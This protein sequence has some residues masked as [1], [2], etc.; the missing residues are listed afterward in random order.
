MTHRVPAV[1]IVIVNWNTRDLLVDCVRSVHTLAK[2]ECRVE[3]VIV[4][5]NASS[6]D[7]LAR[8]KSDP[9]VAG[10]PVRIVENTRNLGFAA[11]C[12]RG[13]RLGTTPYLLFLN[14]DTRLSPRS[15][16]VPVAFLEQP[17]NAKV[18][19]CGIEIVD[20][21][22]EAVSGC[23][24]FPTLR[25]FVGQTTQL[26]TV[27]PALFP[28]HQ[29]SLAELDGARPVDQIIG[30]FF[31]VRR[32]VFDLLGGFDERFFVY[33][34]E[35]DFAYRAKQ[36]GI[37]SYFVP[38][39]RVFHHGGGSTNAVKARRLFLHLRSRIQYTAKHFGPLQA[40]A[41]ALLTVGVELPARLAQAVV[42]RSPRSFAETLSGYAQLLGAGLEAAG[43]RMRSA[44][45]K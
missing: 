15:L 1:D 38:G 18:G 22:G 23:Y 5:D 17:G 45:G 6:D 28:P 41:A 7:S 11:S 16:D 34:E 39:A 33:F 43:R 35:V 37:L 4:V 20:G 44:P 24:R 19:I 8:L 27:A 29:I 42:R 40:T 9:A 10:L 14:P 26:S 31:L 30:A 13:A 2:E 21:T 3:Q 25:T 32:S 12:N 36:R